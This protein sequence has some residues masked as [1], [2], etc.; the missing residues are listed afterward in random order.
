[1]YIVTSPTDVISVYRDTKKLDFDSFIKD[2]MKDFSCTKDTVFKMFD[3][4]GKPKH[5]MDTSHDNFR[6]QMHPGDRFEILQADFLGRINDMLRWERIAGQ[7]VKGF[8]ETS[9]TVSLWEWCGDVL[10][11]AATQTFFGEAIYRVAP[12]VVPDFFTFNDE[13]WKMHYKYPRFAA[14]DM[15]NAK[16]HGEKVFTDYLS[17]PRKERDDAAWIVKQIEQGM[18]DVGIIESTQCGAML[19]NLHRL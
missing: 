8:T 1:M 9:K 16:E 7:P 6:L 2:V 18:E 11:H 17:L 13:A 15:Y 10:V 5:W 19:F 4:N 14:R 12:D 3:M